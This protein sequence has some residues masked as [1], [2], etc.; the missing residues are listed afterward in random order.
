M[1]IVIA[2]L[3]NSKT[4]NWAYET[5]PQPNLGNRR[6]FWPRGKTL[7]GSSSINAMVYIRGHREDYDA[8]GAAADPIWSFDNVLPLFKALEANERFGDRK[9]GVSGKSV[10][11]RVDLGGRRIIKKKK[12]GEEYD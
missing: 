9:R 4:L 2:L 11:V 10:S 7:G 5:E 8:W 3:S 1:P 6:L 12:T